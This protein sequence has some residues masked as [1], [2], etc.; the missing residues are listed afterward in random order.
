MYKKSLLILLSVVILGLLLSLNVTQEQ[1]QVCLVPIA[2]DPAT[3]T[4]Y[5][6]QIQSKS[7]LKIRLLVLKHCFEQMADTDANLALEAANLAQTKGLNIL[8]IG[9]FYINRQGQT[10][11]LVFDQ[12]VYADGLKDFISQ[13]MKVNAETGDTLVIFTIGHGAPEGNLQFLGQRKDIFNVI[14]QAAADNKQETVWWQ[15]SCYASAYLPPINS[16]GND[17]QNLFSIVASSDEYT[18]SPA[19]VEGKIMEKVFLALG[20]KD[21]QID[22]DL[23]EIVTAGELANFLDII[24]PG[25]GK[26]VYAKSNNESLFGIGLARLIPIIDR[27]QPNRV[28]PN[29]YIQYPNQ[30][31]P[32]PNYYQK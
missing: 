3:Q 25:R 22:P 2:T 31:I 1:E 29:D 32:I 13:Q 12:K 20:N 23:N 24:K 30:S 11:R 4:S 8:D 17:K 16:L 21:K 14:S 15:L 18:E 26:L 19:Y 6:G 10:Q 9:N 7:G 5:I 28:Y 27:L